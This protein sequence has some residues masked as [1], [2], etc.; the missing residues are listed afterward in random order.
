MKRTWLTAVSVAGV[1][2]TGSAA[3]MAGAAMNAGSAS[4]TNAPVPDISVP[5]S[6]VYQVGAA[7]RIEVSDASGVLS[8]VSTN[9]G[10]G[11]T[12]VST[13]APGATASVVLTDGAQLVTFT[14]STVAGTVHATVTSALVAAPETT[15][16]AIVSQDPGAVTLEPI[17]AIPPVVAASGTQAIGGASTS[18]ASDSGHQSKL[19]TSSH[20]NDDD[21]ESDD[22]GSDSNDD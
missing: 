20:H 5:R 2:G 21:N 11:W 19:G 8:I 10:T 12:V 7:A 18:G 15:A 17:P 9:V 13:S 6:A 3:V 4:P 1:L 16:P 14:A 22:E